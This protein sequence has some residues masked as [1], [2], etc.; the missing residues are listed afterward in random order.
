[1]GRLRGAQRGFPVLVVRAMSRAVVCD[2]HGWVFVM[3]G[4]YR[5]RMNTPEGL[6]HVPKLSPQMSQ[7][8][9]RRRLVLLFLVH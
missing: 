7:F 9:G 2:D 4:Q 3:Y 8:Q 6:S 1:M 5:F